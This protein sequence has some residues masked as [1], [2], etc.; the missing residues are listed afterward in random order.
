M[1]ITAESLNME[2]VNNILLKTFWVNRS[3]NSHVEELGTCFLKDDVNVS[4]DELRDLLPFCGLDRVIALLVLTEI[5]HEAT[6]T[7]I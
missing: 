2:N 6:H 4:S 7:Q 5:L 3:F 1:K